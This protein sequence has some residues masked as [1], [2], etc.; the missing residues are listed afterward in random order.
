MRPTRGS[1]GRSF[2]RPRIVD[3][4]IP[5][6]GYFF[7][8]RNFSSSFSSR[9]ERSFA[10]DPL[11]RSN[12]RSRR[13]ARPRPRD[14]RARAPDSLWTRRRWRSEMHGAR[15][16]ETPF[17][18][19]DRHG[20]PETTPFPRRPVSNPVRAPDK[21][22]PLPVPVPDHRRSNGVNP[23]DMSNG[24]GHHE[25]L[26]RVRRR[27][28]NRGSS[29]FTRVSDAPER[30]LTAAM[31]RAESFRRPTPAPGPRERALTALVPTTPRFPVVRS[32]PIRTGTA[33]P[34]RP[35]TVRRRGGRPRRTRPRRD[36]RSMRSGFSP[37]SA[38][39]RGGVPRWTAPPPA[40]E[41]AAW[42][43]TA[44]SLA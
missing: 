9:V 12:A 44:A 6:S 32:R 3:R 15:Y 35:L 21:T 17:C 18:R 39:G 11:R 19:R 40:C 7:F 22:P 26:Y 24:S 13:G 31:D 25:G 29:R 38:G 23:P 27:S 1:A 43:A 37:S 16:G 36:R 28:E 8:V 41:E 42:G 14:A 10:T 5:D 30:H 34:R 20:R 33:T 4:R 2:S